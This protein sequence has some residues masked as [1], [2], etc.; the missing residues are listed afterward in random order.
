MTTPSGYIFRPVTTSVG[1]LPFSDPRVHFGSVT[2]SKVASSEVRWP[3]GIVQAH[4]YVAADDVL[5]T[6]GPQK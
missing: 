1:L 6:E 2:E 5:K 4:T 3:S